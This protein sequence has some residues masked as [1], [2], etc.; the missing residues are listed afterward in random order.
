MLNCVIVD[1]EQFAI[2]ALLKYI[3]LMPG[4]RVSGIYTDSLQALQSVSTADNID[5]LFM[6]IDMPSLSGLEL[7]SVLRP[8]TRRL[9]FTT[10]HSR[11][12][13]EA[14]EVAGD[15]FLL[16]PYSFAKFST[17]INRLFTEMEQPSQAVQ[18]R[19]DYFLVKSK[20]DDLAIIRIRY[21]EIIAFESA[22]N[23]I[24]IHLAGDRT[25]IAYL[26]LK[27][28][29][30]LTAARPEFKQFHRAFI[31]STWNISQIRG[32]IVQMTNHLSFPV[33]DLYKKQFSA[34][35]DE[36]LLTTSRK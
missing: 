10:A 36:K 33:G 18:E 11:Y 7:A 34:Y 32:N 23:Y 30:Q 28:I 1:D 27:D 17:T 6:D 5:L 35:L 14:Y 8:K 2:D 20:A 29:L 19:D 16:K 3:G 13:F 25:L 26:T 22:Q 21:D 12:A 9:I 15:A 24:R 31:I 4:L